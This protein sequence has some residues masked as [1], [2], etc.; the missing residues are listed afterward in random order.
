MEL[1]EKAKKE[2]KQILQKEIG[3]ESVSMLTDQE[4]NHL[5]VFFLSIFTES[6]KMKNLKKS[7]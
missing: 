2:L 7:I 4:I 3:F 5:G 1:S 6:L